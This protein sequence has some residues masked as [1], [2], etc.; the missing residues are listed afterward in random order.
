MGLKKGKNTMKIS[1]ESM[2]G[3]VKEIQALSDTIKSIPWT[4]AEIQDTEMGMHITKLESYLDSALG[5][6]SSLYS[7]S[8]QIS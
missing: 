8:K 6:A 4:D 3:L 5:R 7:R 1:T 2:L